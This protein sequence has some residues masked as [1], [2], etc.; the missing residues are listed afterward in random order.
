MRK[1]MQRVLRRSP[2]WTGDK[3]HALCV[4]SAVQGCGSMQLLSVRKARAGLAAAAA[5]SLVALAPAPPARAQDTAPIASA[6]SS[7]PASTLQGAEL[8]SAL[9][10]GGYVV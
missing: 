2:V 3:G 6:E 7:A 5:A 4:P 10:R 9:R 1:W 8:V